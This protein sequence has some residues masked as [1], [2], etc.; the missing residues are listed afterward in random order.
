VSPLGVLSA[1]AILKIDYGQAG[2]SLTATITPAAPAAQ[3]APGSSLEYTLTQ[4]T[5][6]YHERI[7]IT[8]AVTEYDPIAVAQALRQIANVVTPDLEAAPPPS[9][10]D[11]LD[12]ALPEATTAGSLVVPQLLFGV[13]PLEDGWAQLPFLNVTDQI[14]TDILPEPA[15]APT[16]PSLFAGG[17]SFGTDRAELFNVST[18]EP[19]WAVSVIGALRFSGTWTLQNRVLTSIDLT[20]AEPKLFLKGLFWLASAAPTPED[21]LPVLDDFLGAIQSFPLQTPDPTDI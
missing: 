21:A 3:A 18:G 14:L 12:G 1:N 13:M 16:V 10:G 5:D 11:R 17:T 4:Q 7:T 19:A 9:D 8:E 20:L 15:P 6:G 2:G